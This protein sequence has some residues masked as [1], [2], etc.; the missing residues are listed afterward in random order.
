MILRL[1]FFFGLKKSLTPNFSPCGEGLGVRLLVSVLLKL[2]R[3]DKNS[4]RITLDYSSNHNYE[5]P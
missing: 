1:P 3:T 5:L 4:V 2:L